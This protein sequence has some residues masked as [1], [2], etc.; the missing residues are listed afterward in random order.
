[1]DMKKEISFRGKA[2]YPTKKY[3]N[4]VKQE[5]SRRNT[6]LEL[7]LF[8]VFLVLLLVAAKFAVVDLLMSGMNSST[9]LTQAKA[10]LAE[11]EAANANY[12]EITD[13][14]SRYVIANP[15]EAE[16]NLVNRDILLDLMKT[17]VMS[18]TN[19][20]SLKVTGNTITIVCVSIG[21]QE[22][23]VLVESLEGDERVAHVTV[24]TAQAKDGSPSS[25]TIE[26]SLKGALADEAAAAGDI[27]A[28]MEGA[29]NG[30]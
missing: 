12:S 24:S 9:E 1:M 14:F 23:A 11:L 20:T 28:L 22:V 8:A 17:K 5:T 3:V 6:I 21:L 19:L 25:A 4:L 2:T 13:K 15:T 18:A 29:L 26:V 30:K 10:Q 27:D 16:Q 7:A